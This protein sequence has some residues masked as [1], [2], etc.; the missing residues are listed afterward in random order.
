MKSV[1]PY[2]YQATTY[3]K[4]PTYEQ[5]YILN[6][7]SHMTQQSESVVQFKENE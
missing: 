2:Q 6:D 3:T 5:V 1:I 4:I 7:K